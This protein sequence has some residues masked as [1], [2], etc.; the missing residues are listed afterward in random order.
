MKGN[1]I[2]GAHDFT[3]SQGAAKHYMKAQDKVKRMVDLA[4]EIPP[5][6]TLSI[7]KTVLRKYLEVFF[8]HLGPS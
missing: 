8:H 6:D 5:I 7:V 2:D 3:P 4:K 1:G